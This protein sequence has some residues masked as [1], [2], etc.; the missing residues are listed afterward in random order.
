LKY[1]AAT[2]AALGLGALTSAVGTATA[3]ADSLGILLDYSAGVLSAADIKSAGA[4]GAIR[5]V[6]DRRPGASWM[7]GKPMQLA[8]AQDLYDAGLKIGY[9]GIEVMY[10]T[11]TNTRYAGAGAHCDAIKVDFGAVKPCNVLIADVTIDGCA[12]GVM[13]IHVVDGLVGGDVTLRRVRVVN[14][15]HPCHV[16]GK[17]A[18]V[19]RLVVDG[20]PGIQIVGAARDVVVTD[21]PGAVVFGRRYEAPTPPPPP[22]TV[23]ELQAQVAEL[24][25]QLVA[26]DAT[27]TQLEAERADLR[28]KLAA[29]N[30]DL[31][32]LMA[33]LVIWRAWRD[34]VLATAPK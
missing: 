28:R 25:Q 24:R 29:A 19:G 2:P 4:L 8:E 33:E 31:D 27:T 9:S 18:I 17:Q 15:V 30:T 22:P 23:A 6:S 13:P 10:G 20:C 5:Y 21:S 7:L 11:I 26:F 32:H 14:S 1:A 3:S 16:G 12:S 34:N